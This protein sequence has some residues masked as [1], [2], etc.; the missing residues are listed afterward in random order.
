MANPS[1]KMSYDVPWGAYWELTKP[2]IIF[3]VLVTCA[4]GFF[5]GG[6]GIHSYTL[7]FATLLGTALT[8]GG[9]AVLNHYLERDVDRL[10]ERTSRAAIDGDVVRVHTRAAR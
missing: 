7:L 8:V 10:M 1:K 9:S 5:V 3:M 2:R 6:R 4:L